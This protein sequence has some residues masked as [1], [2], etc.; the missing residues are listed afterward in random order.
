[1]RTMTKFLEAAEAIF[2]RHGY[3]GTTV[4]DIAA[5]SGVNLGTLK[6]YWGSK[7]ELF[8][9]LIERRLRSVHAVTAAR[10]SAL[11]PRRANGKAPD[12]GNIVACLVEPAF[13]VGVDSPPDLDF[14]DAT[15]RGRFHL[16]FGRCLTDPAPAIVEDL[17]EMFADVTNR[18]FRL[19][20]LACP[21][22]SQAE[23]DW[24]INCVFGMVS[25]AQLYGERIGRFVGTTADVGDE[26]ASKW[27]MHLILEGIGAPPLHAGA[28]GRARGQAPAKSQRARRRKADATR[29]E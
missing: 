6:H 20:R 22:L 9:D 4:R 18:F 8:R 15:A 16:F 2:G 29:P 23:L 17:N 10:L 21:G 27:V 7:R 13:L 11:D 5:R 14:S 19:M 12:P 24:R 28:R 1:M 3:E 25:F 26:I